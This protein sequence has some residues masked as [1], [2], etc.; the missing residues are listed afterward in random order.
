VLTKI[1]KKLPKPITSFSKP[2]SETL[3]MVLLVNSPKLKTY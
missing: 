2:V 1:F 3:L